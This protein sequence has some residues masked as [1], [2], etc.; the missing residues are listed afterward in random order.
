MPSPLLSAASCWAPGAGR[1]ALAHA[2]HILVSTAC[3]SRR[4]FCH[5]SADHEQTA[6][7]S[8][9][10]ST[11]H[12][13]GQELIT[14]VNRL[15]IHSIMSRGATEGPQAMK[16]LWWPRRGFAL[17]WSKRGPYVLTQLVCHSAH[18]E[19]LKLHAQLRSHA[20]E[21]MRKQGQSTAATTAAGMAARAAVLFKPIPLIP[22]V[23]HASTRGVRACKAS[24]SAPNPACQKVC[25]R[26]HSKRG[27]ELCT[28]SRWA[29]REV[30]TLATSAHARM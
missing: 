12:T 6:W 29:A 18:G 28:L 21:L 14:P 27:G 25:M 10:A 5:P 3:A 13:Q 1:H 22:S 9:R 24:C 20:Y 7:L 23:S 4:G 8:C 26:A 30:H 17:V 11:A 19:R 16:K 15:K 2:R